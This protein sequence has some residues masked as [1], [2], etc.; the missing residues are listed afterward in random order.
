MFLL[1]SFC[2]YRNK[3]K[4]SSHLS[5]LHYIDVNKSFRSLY[6][7]LCA[8]QKS[9]FVK[10]LLVLTCTCYTAFRHLQCLVSGFC[11]W[12]LL[13]V[14][15][16]GWS[17]QVCRSVDNKN[18]SFHWWWLSP[19][20]KLFNLFILQWYESFMM[21]IETLTD[22]NIPCMFPCELFWRIDKPVNLLYQI[23]CSSVVYQL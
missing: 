16:W 11:I 22:I 21:T 7:E 17:G 8:W 4:V 15:G 13:L 20:W 10:S 18:N 5:F 14:Y 2:E 3:P 19:L 6:H 1:L 12:L 9:W 23:C